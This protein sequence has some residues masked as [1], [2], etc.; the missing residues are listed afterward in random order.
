MS[1]SESRCVLILG[2]AGM[3]GHKLNQLYRERFDVYTT[4][5]RSFADYKKYGIFDAERTIDGVNV[6]D[7]DK[8]VDVLATVKPNVVINCIGI[9]KQLKAAK[10]PIVSLKINSLFPHQLANICR[11]LNAR[12]IHIST[13]CVFDGAKGMYTEQDPSNA[14]DLYGRTK[15]LGEVDR[16]GCLTLRTSIIGRQLSTTSGL[17]EWFLS[18]AVGSVNGFKKAI[19]SGFTTIALS[20][21]IADIIEN[22]P[23]LSGLYQVS[24]DPID[25]YSLLCLIRDSFGLDIEIQADEDFVLDRSLDSTRF[26]LA[27]G[28]NPPKWPDMIK[29]MADD[30]TPYDKWRNL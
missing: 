19:Y 27:T 16:P 7:F 15:F 28:F 2:A 22:Y 18:N 8:V 25:K 26:K 30:P 12:L 14:T 11:A 13:D 10:D 20:E 3:L 24:S 4:V 17:L 6:A 23:E 1:K 5:R 29:Q 9:I 21:I